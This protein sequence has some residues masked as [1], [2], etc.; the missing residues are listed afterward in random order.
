[1]TIWKA[2]NFAVSAEPNYRCF[3]LPAIRRTLRIINFV[4]N[5]EVISPGPYS[6][7]PQKHSSK[8]PS[9]HL[10]KMKPNDAN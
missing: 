7:L 5:V 8:H 9:K 4:D 1:M 3:A 10:R 6:P 2:I